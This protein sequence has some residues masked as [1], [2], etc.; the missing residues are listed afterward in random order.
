L[1]HD[2]A[3]HEKYGRFLEPILQTML[4]KEPNRSQVRRLGEYLN[5]VYSAQVMQAHP[6]Y[7]PQ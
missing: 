2:K 7:K 4:A 3:T 6:E 1:R 5:A